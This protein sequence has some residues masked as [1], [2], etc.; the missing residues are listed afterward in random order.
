ML[1]WLIS[2]ALAVIEFVTSIWTRLPHEA[3]EKIIEVILEQFKSLL[4]GYFRA[5]HGS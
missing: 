3:K 1:T 2:L 4:R 5:Y